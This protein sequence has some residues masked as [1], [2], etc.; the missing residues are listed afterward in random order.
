MPTS[1]TTSKFPAPSE[2]LL[3]THLLI[4]SDQ[5]RSRESYHRIKGAEIVRERDP[6]A[7]RLSNSWLILNSAGGPT[8]DNRMSSPRRRKAPTF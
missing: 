2:G 3:V 7:L 1:R 4:V 6:V 8:D 5:E